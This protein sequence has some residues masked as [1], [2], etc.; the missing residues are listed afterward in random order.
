MVTLFAAVVALVMIQGDRLTSLGLDKQS[1]ESVATNGATGEGQVAEQSDGRSNPA[2]AD[3]KRNQQGATNP[4][5][6]DSNSGDGSASTAGD[7]QNQTRDVQENAKAPA[8]W[9]DLGLKHLGT[10]PVDEITLIKL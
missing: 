8:T 1:P 9:A 3:E 5:T 4:V 10:Y 2:D 7:Q 6:A